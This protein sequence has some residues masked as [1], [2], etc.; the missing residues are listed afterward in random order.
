MTIARD[1]LTC[2]L[3]DKQSETIKDRPFYRLR[4][5][6]QL[7]Q[8]Q[9][10]PALCFVFM[11]P[12]FEDEGSL[13]TNCATTSFPTIAY[14]GSHCVLCAGALQDPGSERVFLL[15]GHTGNKN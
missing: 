9:T 13:C 8:P 12:T 15:C 3:S 11:Q 7:S 1:M 4:L 10:M 5:I 2:Y 14:G 6:M